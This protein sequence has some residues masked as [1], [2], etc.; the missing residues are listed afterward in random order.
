M[1]EENESS[2]NKIRLLHMRLENNKKTLNACQKMVGMN[3]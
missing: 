3:I 1:K 2:V